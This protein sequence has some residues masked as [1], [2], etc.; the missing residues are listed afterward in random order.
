M[1]YNSIW[2]AEKFGEIS[3]FGKFGEFSS[4]DQN[5]CIIFK[6]FI[7][8]YSCKSYKNMALKK[9]RSF[10]LHVIEQELLHVLL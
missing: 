9:T 6:G 1:P 5:V 2:E 3:S 7:V 8:D 10:E 4:F